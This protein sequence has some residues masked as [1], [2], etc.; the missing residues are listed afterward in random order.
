MVLDQI[1]AY[2]RDF[3]AHRQSV[4]PLAGL[5]TRLADQPAPPDF[6]KAIRR[7]RQQDIRV[8]AEVKKASPSKGL[9]RA[10]FDPVRIASQY[11]EAQ[12][13]AISVLTDE[14]FFQGHLDYLKQVRSAVSSIPLLR[15][16][17]VISEY[18]IYEAREAGAAAVLLITAI[19]DRKELTGFRELAHE[20]G[21]AALTEVHSEREADDAAESGA[22]LIGVNNR[23]LRD[24]AVD[25]KQT[26]RIIR[27]LGAPMEGYTLVS[28][29]GI[30]TPDDVDWL[31]SMPV[32]AILVGESLMR[33]EQPGEALRVLLGYGPSAGMQAQT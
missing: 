5:K 26:E 31:R 30:S 15:K 1:V 16:D 18:Q 21:M 32:D 22:K 20:L 24:F 28:E 14:K 17:F 6:A 11:A 25:L 19:L 10:D 27:L 23:D 7:N 12:A 9:I 13:A 4:Q 29:S 3:V 2:K 8:I 33:K